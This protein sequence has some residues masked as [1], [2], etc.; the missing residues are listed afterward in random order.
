MHQDIIGEFDAVIEE[1][2]KNTYSVSFWGKKYELPKLT[3][4]TTE[5]FRQGQKAELNAELNKKNGTSFKIESKNTPEEDITDETPLLSHH[6]DSSSNTTQEQLRNYAADREEGGG[7]YWDFLY[8]K[9]FSFWLSD[10]IS[11]LA[12]NMG[13][14]EESTDYLD[15][16]FR[17]TKVSA[18]EKLANLLDNSEDDNDLLSQA[19]IHAL[20]EGT[21]GSIVTQGGG[22]EVILKDRPSTYSDEEKKSD[23]KKFQ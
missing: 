4:S 8:L 23:S 16:K 3:K 7:F 10:S 1:N 13:L 15:S 18:A 5:E 22:L 11:S 19:E 21:L 17:D 2:S 20:S 12:K 6:G 9:T 14:I